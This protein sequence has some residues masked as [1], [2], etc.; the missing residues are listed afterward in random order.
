MKEIFDEDEYRYLTELD[1]VEYVFSTI[2]YDFKIHPIAA[3]QIRELFKR[4]YEKGKKN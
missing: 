4:L 1:A 3:K 2:E